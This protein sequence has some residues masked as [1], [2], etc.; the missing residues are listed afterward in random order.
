[1]G[2]GCWCGVFE[3]RELG[4][5]RFRRRLAKDKARIS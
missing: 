5:V 2:R 4:L 3:P 1:M